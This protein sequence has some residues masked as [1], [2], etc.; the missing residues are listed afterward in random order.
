MKAGGWRAG[1]DRVH[2]AGRDRRVD[3]LK[4]KQVLLALKA[5]ASESL[6]GS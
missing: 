6:D 4:L 2:T 3:G 1:V 5:Q